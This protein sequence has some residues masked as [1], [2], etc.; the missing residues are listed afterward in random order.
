MKK[1]EASRRPDKRSSTPYR[2]W[3]KGRH[4]P[5][6]I[7]RDHLWVLNGGPYE[8]NELADLFV[9]LPVDVLSKCWMSCVIDSLTAFEL[10]VGYLARALG[11]VSRRLQTRLSAQKDGGPRDATEEKK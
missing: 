9:S 11:V 2:R 6:S 3:I 5:I 8:M 4:E 7:G 1:R 10:D